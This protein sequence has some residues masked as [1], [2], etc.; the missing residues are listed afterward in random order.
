MFEQGPIDL[1]FYERERGCVQVALDLDVGSTGSNGCYQVFKG[2]HYRNN[3]LFGG[4]L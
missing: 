1:G 3:D 2:I 4:F